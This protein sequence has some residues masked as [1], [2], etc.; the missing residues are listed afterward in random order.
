[1][2]EENLIQLREEVVEALTYTT[3]QANKKLLIWN[4]E[5]KRWKFKLQDRAAR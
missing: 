4:Q 2:M 5:L 1:M 3:Q